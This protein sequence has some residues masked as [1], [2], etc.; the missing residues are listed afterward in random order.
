MLT[1]KDGNVKK[2]NSKTVIGFDLGMTFSQISYFGGADEEPQTV[3]MITGTQM[4][5]IPTVLAKRPGVGQWFF[6]R[7]ALKYAEND[8]ILVDD[9]LTKALRGEEVI[10]ENEPYDPVALLTLFIKRSLG[11]LS[12][13]VSLKDAD[14]FM[15]TVE[16]LTPRTVEVLSRVV[17][18]LQLRCESITYQ[19][20]LESFFSYMIHQPPQLWQEKVLALEYNDS[21]KSMIFECTKNTTPSVVFI[22]VKNHSEYGKMEWDADEEIRK[23]QGAMLDE[24]FCATCEE[25]IKGQT[26]GTV[27]LLGDCFKEEWTDS[28]LKLLCK[29]RRVFQG[30]NLYSKGACYAMMDKLE[31]SELSKGYVY[32][33]EDKIKSNIGMKVLRRGADS[34]YAI[35]D[36]G[37]NWYE[38]YKDFDIIL[39]EGNRISFVLTSLTGGH[40]TER[41]VMLD[42]L[43]QRPRGTT[44]LRLHVELSAVNTMIVEVEDMG[45]GEIIKSSGLAWT[46]TL[47]I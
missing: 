6:G 19:S 39:D 18:S 41:Q 28:T 15:F 23:N 10:V 38:A 33:G 26:I 21:L 12:M 14:A 42:G 36:A 30:N 2:N 27:Y 25:L 11:L 37:T 17:A 40:V 44:R 7:E 35:I 47:R 43:P 24:K 20:H 46:H 13:N 4:Y 34:Y 22:N 16:E 31:P 3:S 45:F 5:N 9:L 1:I 29:N 32:L 8:G